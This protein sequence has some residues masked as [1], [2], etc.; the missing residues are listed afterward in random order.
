MFLYE[1]INGRAREEAITTFHKEHALRA[2][3]EA[4]MAE[5]DRDQFAQA[6]KTLADIPSLGE[7]KDS[8]AKVAKDRRDKADKLH[9]LANS[10][11]EDFI[12]ELV[13]RVR[14]ALENLELEHI[15]VAEKLSNLDLYG[16]DPAALEMRM[17]LIESAILPLRARYAKLKEVEDAVDESRPTRFH[18]PHGS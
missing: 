16:E 4:V 17:T 5:N 9:K 1:I 3:W 7:L 12:E 15:R 14:L 13:R 2:E 18:P 11:E 6:A 10:K 8:H